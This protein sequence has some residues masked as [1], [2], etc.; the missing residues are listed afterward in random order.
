MKLLTKNLAETEIK[1]E[2]EELLS[3]NI[4]LRKFWQ[5]ITQKLNNARDNYEPE[6]MRALKD[7]EDFCK[8]LLAKKSELLKE[9][10]GIRNEIEKKKEIYFGMIEKQDLLQEKAYQIK[11][12]GEKLRLRESFVEDLERKWQEKQGQF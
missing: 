5:E 2:N 9:L 4:R 12:E 1:R 3:T 11:E 6:K 7:Y 10:Q 8:T